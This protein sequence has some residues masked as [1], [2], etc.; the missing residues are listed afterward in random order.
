MTTKF[1]EYSFNL[2]NVVSLFSESQPE[3]SEEPVI[4][5]SEVEG[6]VTN[7]ATIVHPIKHL[8]N[9]PILFNS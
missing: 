9:P 4:D 1:Q 8:L 5:E 7:Y 2:K 3:A 6:I